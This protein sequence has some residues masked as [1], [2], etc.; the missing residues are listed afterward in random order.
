[1]CHAAIL[2]RLS[3]A[4]I[5]VSVIYQPDPYRCYSRTGQFDFEYHKYGFLF[6]FY[7]QGDHKVSE[8]FIVKSEFTIELAQTAISLV[9]VRDTSG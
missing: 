1:M 8:T 5:G 2:G 9:A 4:P 7:S 3:V 6:N